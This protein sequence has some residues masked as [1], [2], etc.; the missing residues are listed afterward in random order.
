MYLLVVLV[1]QIKNQLLID[2]VEEARSYIGTPYFYKGRSRGG[3]DCA[4]IV[5]RSLNATII[6]GYDFLDYA[7]NANPRHVKKELE[8]ISDETNVLEHGSILL[9]NLNNLPS[10]IAI[11]TDSNTIIHS[12]KRRGKVVEE[13]FTNYW[14][15]KLD[16]IYRVR[17]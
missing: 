5:C 9:L 8:N 14:K 7:L 3:I 11:Y 12:Y 6:P 1:K 2:F 10:H 15:D 16:S 13:K 4:G 17:I